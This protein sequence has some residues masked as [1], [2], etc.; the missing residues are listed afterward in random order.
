L[1]N[2]LN[3]NIIEAGIKLMAGENFMINNNLL[4]RPT[5]VIY[6]PGIK[7]NSEKDYY[8]IKKDTIEEV[9]ISVNE[10]IKNIYD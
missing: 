3:L 8:I 2:S 4:E 1:P 9:L 7:L 5:S 6:Y 10:K